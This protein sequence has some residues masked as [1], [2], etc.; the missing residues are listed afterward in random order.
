MEEH[1][2]QSVLVEQAEDETC[3]IKLHH[4]LQRSDLLVGSCGQAGPG[5]KCGPHHVLKVGSGPEA[6]KNFVEYF[7]KGVKH[8]WPGL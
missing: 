1:G 4:Y 6:Y 8:T 3:I 5:H 2:I 7:Q